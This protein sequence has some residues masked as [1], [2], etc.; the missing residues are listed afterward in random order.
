M[1][2]LFNGSKETT[3]TTPAAPTTT[4]STVVTTSS[5]P[6][7]YSEVMCES[8]PAQ[9]SMLSFMAKPKKVAFDTQFQSEQILLV[10]RRHIIT[11]VPWVITA[12]IFA[13]LPLG[14]GLFPVLGTLPPNYTFAVHLGWYLL[15]TGFVLESFLSWFFNVYIITDER[16]IDVDFVSLIY[17]RVSIAKID[18]IEDVTAQSGGALQS[19]FNYGSVFVQTAAEKREFDFADVPKPAVVTQLLNELIL[20]E[21]RE[22]LEGRV[23]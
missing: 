14:F 10:L 16:I 3:P 2:E 20:Q 17:K 1:P 4:T 11:Q 13:F 18:N 8:T 7:S 15:L 5:D 6:N 23:S 12:V 22:K 19:I 9:H 21:E